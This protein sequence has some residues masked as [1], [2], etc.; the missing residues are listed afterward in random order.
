MTRPILDRLDIAASDVAG[1]KTRVQWRQ[2]LWDV[3]RQMMD[4]VDAPV[5]RRRTIAGGLSYLVIDDLPFANTDLGERLLA[6]AEEYSQ[7]SPTVA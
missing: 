3:L 1:A 4:E 2:E 7:D 6:L 5:D